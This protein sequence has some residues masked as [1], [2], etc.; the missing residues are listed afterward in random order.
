MLEELGDGL[1]QDR[2]DAGARDG[3]LV[4]PDRGLADEDAGHVG[5]RVARPRVELADPE[6]VVAKALAHRPTI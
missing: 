2:G 6:A 1:G 3:R 5:D 4:S